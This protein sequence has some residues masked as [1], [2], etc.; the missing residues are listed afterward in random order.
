M[1]TMVPD[2]LRALGL[3]LIMACP[4]FAPIISRLKWVV[5]DTPATPTAS[6]SLQGVVRVNPTW[7]MSL[8]PDERPYIIA[9]ECGHLLYDT[10]G[11]QGRRDPKLWNVATDM[12]INR[13]L[14]ALPGLQAPKKFPVLVAQGDEPAEEIYSKLQQQMDE[15]KGKEP[16]D[17]QFGRG[18]GVG[19]DGTGQPGEG[20]GDGDA[21]EGLSGMTEDQLRQVW[22]EAAAA[23][24][25]IAENTRKAGTESAGIDAFVGLTAVPAARV[26]FASLIRSQS[27][28]ATSG[29]GRDDWTWGRR[30]RR[31]N[32]NGSGVLLPGWTGKRPQIAVVIDSSGSMSDE[33]VSVCCQQAAAASRALDVGIYLVIHDAV[34]GWS[35][36]LAGNVTPQRVAGKVNVRGGTAFTPAYNNVG[37]ARRGSVPAKF[38]ALIHLTDG[39]LCESHWPEKPVNCK[40]LIVGLVNDAPPAVPEGTTIVKIVV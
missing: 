2:D 19:D 3:R 35:G 18:C 38:D 12:A 9:H 8:E 28:Q 15:N 33:D 1:A 10:F 23:S 17:G 21:A 37:E 32:F 30:G 13:R 40:K 39:G 26:P 27:A 16:G 4:Y 11:R 29:I 36:W 22:R 24:R 34:V 20:E 31:S 6:V 5:D 7:L 25:V 14:N